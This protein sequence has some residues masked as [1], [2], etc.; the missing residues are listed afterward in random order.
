MTATL[1]AFLL[2]S[3]LLYSIVGYSEAINIDGRFISVNESG[4]MFFKDNGEILSANEQTQVNNHLVE[5]GL[6][7]ALPASYLEQPPVPAGAGAVVDGTTENGAIPTVTL[8]GAD[9]VCSM[10]EGFGG[11][12]KERGES[13]TSSTSTNNAGNTTYTCACRDS[14]GISRQSTYE[15]GEDGSLTNTASNTNGALSEEQI[16]AANPAPESG[17]T[18]AAAQAQEQAQAQAQAQADQTTLATNLKTFV[19][20][21]DANLASQMNADPEKTVSAIVLQDK[22]SIFADDTNSFLGECEQLLKKGTTWA[23]VTALA[24]QGATKEQDISK[25]F[26]FSYKKVF[27]DLSE[28]LSKGSLSNTKIGT[29][30]RNSFVD[31]QKLTQK[32]QHC[33]ALAFMT[34]RV[35]YSDRRTTSVE[36]IDSVK[37]SFDQKIKAQKNGVETQDYPACSK[38]IDTYNA[39]FLGGQALQIGQT[40]QF[41]EASMDASIKAQENANDITAGMVAQK[42]MTDEQKKIANTKAAFSGAKGA[43]MFAALSSIPTA[44]DLIENCDNNMKDDGIHASA[45]YNIYFEAVQSSL[46]GSGLTGITIQK[47]AGLEE[48]SREEQTASAGGGFTHESQRAPAATGA[49]GTPAANVPYVAEVPNLDTYKNVNACRQAAGKKVSL[50]MNEVS[51]RE[52]IKKA[53][54]EAGVETASNLLKAKLLDDQSDMIG[55]AINNVKKFDEDN[56][57]PTFEEFNAE[58]C[59][60]DPTLPE[61]ANAGPVFER[62]REFNGNGI[63]VSGFSRQNTSAGIRREDTANSDKNDDSSDNGRG[64]GVTG[65]GTTVGAPKNSTGFTDPSPG[66]GS[67]K[68][69][70]G[71]GAG[72]GGGGGVGKAASSGGGGGGIGGGGGS[73]GVSGGNSRRVSFTGGGGGLSFGGGGKGGSRKVASKGGNPFSK[74]FKNKKGGKKGGTLNFRG[75]ASVGGKKDSLFGMISN[76]YGKIKDDRLIKYKAEK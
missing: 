32:I 12:D 60:A 47:V 73:R 48:I 75:V 28:D 10:P 55:D 72:G 37:K 33:T 52:K 44:K 63:N 53:M 36:G 3:A 14:R 76:R 23:N 43:A 35:D 24:K 46:S 27:K 45:G 16:A 68:R 18:T 34:T 69:G 74:F 71:G 17:T 41:Q 29:D 4:Q 13:L 38:A 67:M 50:T 51:C 8:T 57:A 61:C 70:G 39:A 25:L 31:A 62:G 56:P 59:Q 40:F 54:V 30:I 15:R 22:N 42:E 65:V 26:N 2:L 7:P 1:K 19:E 9:R 11:C 21:L 49:A 5:L 66:A 64:E 6:N 20:N 58:I